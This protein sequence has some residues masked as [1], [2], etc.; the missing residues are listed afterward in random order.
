MPKIVVYSKPYCPY[1]DRAK[2]LLTRKG[3]TFE[4]IDLMTV[5]QIFIGDTHIGGYDDMAA[6]DRQGNLDILLRG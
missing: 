1:C 2:E 3:A 5:P 6:L 4:I